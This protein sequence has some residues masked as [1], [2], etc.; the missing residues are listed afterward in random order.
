MNASSSWPAPI[1][2]MPTVINNRAPKR[3]ARA[4][5]ACPISTKASGIGIIRSPA[6]NAD[7][8]RPTCR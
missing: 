3:I 1:N 8:P 4:P 5:D 7:A 6:T 2:A